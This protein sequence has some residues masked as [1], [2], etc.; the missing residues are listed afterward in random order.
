M[1]PKFL[2]IPTLVL[3]FLPPLA[4]V[5]TVSPFQISDSSKNHNFLP[6]TTFFALV[7]NPN[8]S[9]RFVSD[10]GVCETTPGVHQKSGYITVGKNMHMWFW[11]FESRTSPETAPFTLWLSGGPGCSSMIGLFQENGPCYVNPDS[12][13]IVIN[14]FSWNNIS[15]MIYIDE[16]IGAGFS[17]GNDTVNSTE[18]AAPFVWQAFQVLFESGAFSK[19]VSRELILATD[20]YGG[21]YGPAFVTYFNKQNA[22]IESWLLQGERVEVST[23]IINKVPGA[24]TSLLQGQAYV[25][26]A[27]N[28]PGYG[29][30]QPDNILAQ[31]NQ[32]YFGLGGCREQ[33]LACYAAGDSIDSENICRKADDFCKIQN[34]NV[35]N[36]AAANRDPYD[37]RQNTSALFPFEFYVDLSNLHSTR[38]KIGAEVRYK[39]CPNAP[40]RPFVKTGDSPRMF[41]PQLGPLADSGLKLLIWVSRDADIICNWLGAHASVPAMDWYGHDRLVKTPFTIMTMNGKA[42]AEMLNV[43][44]SFAPVYQAGH[45]VP[46]FQPETSFDSDKSCIK[47]NLTRFEFLRPFFC[48]NFLVDMFRC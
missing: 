47:S 25:D 23:L 35:L 46:A 45:Q 6:Q 8:V 26:F 39:E 32:S 20:S 48:D 29:Q 17:I 30:L 22:L 33:E 4:A 11:F 41:L 40:L 2:F 10:F 27:T 15:N 18:T 1:R 44:F 24:R 19:F 3:A 9:L 36:L 13:T 12:K 38:T 42:V 5:A 31:I 7:K 37:L 34:D 28:A 16:P 43:D 14:S 21:H